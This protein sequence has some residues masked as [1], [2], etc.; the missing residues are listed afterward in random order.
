M[1]RSRLATPALAHSSPSNDSSTTLRRRNARH[2]NTMVGGGLRPCLWKKFAIFIGFKL[3]IPSNGSKND[4]LIMKKL[5]KNHTFQGCAGTGN[6][7]LTKGQCE[8]QCLPSVRSGLSFEGRRWE[9]TPPTHGILESRGKL[10]F[11]ACNGVAPLN[12]EGDYVQRCAQNAQCPAGSWCNSQGYCCP[13]QQT[14]CASPKSIG[15]TCLSQKP[16]T[17]WSVRS[18]NTISRDRIYGLLYRGVGFEK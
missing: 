14:A 15:H 16:G 4:L 6:N 12:D 18:L 9:R 10:V 8:S 13:H 17:F 3:I 5:K 1:N 11:A 2:S 7:F